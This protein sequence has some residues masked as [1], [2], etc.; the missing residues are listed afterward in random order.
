LFSCKDLD[1][2]TSRLA[3]VKSK[4]VTLDQE[5]THNALFDARLTHICHDL[6]MK[7]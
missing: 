3:F 2:D 5:Q 7:C 1:A 4:G 6:L